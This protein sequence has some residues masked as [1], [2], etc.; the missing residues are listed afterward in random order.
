MMCHECARGSIETPCLGQCRFCLVSL[1]KDH[2]VDALRPGVVPSYACG[3]RP[4]LPFGRRPSRKVGR[5][6]QVAQPA[7]ALR[8]AAGV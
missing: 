2:L 1:C 4:E 7:R 5:S 3:H 6:E 8:V